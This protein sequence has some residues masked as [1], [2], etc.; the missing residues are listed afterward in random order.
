MWRRESYTRRS[1][2]KSL[3]LFYQK[4]SDS[5]YQLV[6]LYKKIICKEKIY[7]TFTQLISHSQLSLAMKEDIIPE[8]QVKANHDG[9]CHAKLSRIILILDFV[10]TVEKIKLWLAVPSRLRTTIARWRKDN[11]AQANGLHWAGNMHNGKVGHVRSFG[12]MDESWEP[13]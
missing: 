7:P 11:Q 10:T 9:K 8:F 3:R 1:T 13:V 12:F 4:L 5:R 6:L 2:K